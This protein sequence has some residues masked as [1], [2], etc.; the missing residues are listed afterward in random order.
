MVN[1][2]TLQPQQYFFL[3][4][5]AALVLF[6]L[7]GLNVNGQLF[8]YLYL[9]NCL[10]RHLFIF[11]DCSALQNNGI[12]Y[13][14]KGQIL[15]L[16]W[17][18]FSRFWG[19]FAPKWPNTLIHMKFMKTE[20]PDSWFLQDYVFKCYINYKGFNYLSTVNLIVDYYYYLCWILIPFVSVI[21]WFELIDSVLLHFF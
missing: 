9:F 5:Q 12:I 20:M 6:L 1:I 16:S 14:I 2:F 4:N 13:W 15:Q 11:L 18:K 7:W 17:W 21:V 19:E 3:W 8:F 10:V